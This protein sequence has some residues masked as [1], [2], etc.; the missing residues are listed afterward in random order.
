MCGLAGLISL[1]KNHFDKKLFDALLKTRNLQKHRGPDNFDWFQNTNIAL[2][3]NRLNI[4]DLT[5]NANMPMMDEKTGCV[6]VFNGEVYNYKELYSELAEYNFK[7]QSDTEVV[8]KS[9]IK[10]G[11]KCLSKFNGMFA[12][13][14]WDPRVK[15]LFCARDRM[16]IKPFFYRKIKDHLLFSSEIKPLLLENKKIPNE[17]VIHNYLVNGVY[18]HSEETFFKDIYQLKQ[19]CFLEVENSRINISPY[20]KL[21][22]KTNNQQIKDYT[23]SKEYFLYLVEDSIKL[24]LRSDVPVSLN[25]SGGLDSLT[26]MYLINKI[27]NGQKNIKSFNFYFDTKT[28]EEKYFAEKLSSDLKWNTKYIKISASEIPAL[29]EQCMFY[30][31]QPFPGLPTLGKFKT[32][33]YSK[34]NGSKVIL[35]GQGGDEIAAGYRYTYGSHIKDLI[36]ENTI[37]EIKNE[38]FKFSKLNNLNI[39]EVFSII[40]NGIKS[41][42]NNGYSA[43]GTKSIN[44]NILNNDFLNKFNDNEVYDFQLF[45]KNLKNFQY[46]DLF[47][48]K[49]PRILRSCDRASM[50]FSTELRVPLLDHRIVE[51]MF[52]L[53]SEFKIKN[54]IQRYIYR[55]AIKEITDIDLLNLPK[56]SIVDPQIIWFKKDLK[57][58]I[59]DIINSSIFREMPYFNFKNI[60]SIFQNYI[61]DN[62]VNN[63]VFIWQIISIYYWQKTFFSKG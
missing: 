60:K 3:S 44:H 19:G 29:T 54:G 26:L 48:T 63:S 35:E 13:A 33:K 52:N 32:C 46:K 4:I 36:K 23:N 12:F 18:D 49:L 59:F 8:L 22:H 39:R 25:I 45:D 28:N 31:E 38:I 51:F 5:P 15:K 50:A 43:D 34:L 55:E 37:G 16:G 57:D 30:Q 27:N 7:S 41:F 14:I 42:E 11:S 2:F 56:R 17:K 21:N 47:F 61:S 10:W 24:R 53:K 9:Y 40:K 20:W 58:W 1:K 62:T 6:I